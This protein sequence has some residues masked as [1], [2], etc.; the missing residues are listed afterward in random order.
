LTEKRL[1]SGNRYSRK[2]RA[3]LCHPEQLTCL[4][5]VKSEMNAGNQY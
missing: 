5:Q 2:H 3:P 1:L 4:R